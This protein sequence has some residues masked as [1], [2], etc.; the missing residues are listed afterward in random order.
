MNVIVIVWEGSPLLS[1]EVIIARL[2][3]LSLD[4]G[5]PWESAS[6]MRPLRLS[7]S[8]ASLRTWWTK[9]KSFSLFSDICWLTVVTDTSTSVRSYQQGVW[10]HSL[11]WIFNP[12]V[13]LRVIFV[14]A[15]RRLTAKSLAESLW[16]VKWIK[17]SVCLPTLQPTTRLW[18]C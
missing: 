14:S 9:I 12:C 18:T 13:F 8:A 4:P 17:V 6:V 16:Q 7:L 10:K 2:C 15:A 1:P 3:R 11:T 5:R